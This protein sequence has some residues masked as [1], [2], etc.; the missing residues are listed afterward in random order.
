METGCWK[1]TRKIVKVR[2]PPTTSTPTSNPFAGIHLVP[3]SETDANPSQV[4]VDAQPTSDA[5]VPDEA[6]K[7]LDRSAGDKKSDVKEGDKVP[8]EI[9]LKLDLL[10]MHVFLISSP[11]LPNIGLT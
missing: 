11:A 10:H 8:S 9:L 3:P 7:E 2:R 5:R 1:G 6:N 4:V